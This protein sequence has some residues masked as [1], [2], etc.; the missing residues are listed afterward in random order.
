MNKSHAIAAAA[1]TLAV[2]LG[3]AVYLGYRAENTLTQ[4]AAQGSGGA[5][6]V[7]A[8]QPIRINQVKHDR[9]L[10]RSSGRL[11]FTYV[12]NCA[13]H[14]SGVENFTAQV[15]YALDHLPLPTGLARFEWS[16]T[17]QGT[18]AETFKTLFGSA[19]ALNGQG[20]IG[21]SGAIQSTLGL[22][23]VALRKPGEA[24]DMSPSSGSLSI[25]GQALALQWTLERA[26]V[27]SNGQ[28]LDIQGVG[29]DLD[30]D[31]RSRGT[32]SG[33]FKIAQASISQGSLQGL[34]IKTSAH[35]SND[36]ID[37]TIST[38]LN[39]LDVGELALSDLR[40]EWALRGLHTTSMESLIRLFEDSCGMEALTERESQAAAQAVKTLLTK[41]FSLSMPVLTG[42]T[43]QGSVSGSFAV[44]LVQ[45]NTD[46]PS[47]AAQFRS[48][49][50]IALTGQVISQEQREMALATGF[51]M[52]QG[53]TLSASYEYAKGLFK[54]NT[55]TMDASFFEDLLVGA[56]QGVNSLLAQLQAKSK[57]TAAPP[58]P[59]ITVEAPTAS[60]E[61]APAPPPAPPPAPTATP[62]APVQAPATS[63]AQPPGTTATGPACVTLTTCVQQTLIAAQQDDLERVRRIATQ[64]DVLPKPDLG[65]KAVARKLNAA[66]LDALK[67]GDAANAVSQLRR[68]RQENP[69][70]VEIAAN[71]GFALL[72]AGDPSA[73]R[74]VLGEALLL[75]PRR[76]ATWGP[77]A[78]ALALIGQM[79]DAKAAAWVAFQWSGNREKLRAVYLDRAANETEP[80]LAQLYG[81][82]AN[83]ADAA[84]AGE[85]TK[86]KQ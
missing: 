78:D 75:N 62:D 74:A 61:P 67:Q 33:A 48:K 64:I 12:P 31:N 41:G 40:M 52:V 18:S 60:A 55:R 36:R 79:N 56:D 72:K 25:K 26:T 10:F 69:Q 84:L 11:T 43:Q 16:L 14:M 39:R 46:S 5:V 6:T 29:I 51:A 54:V 20:V 86:A 17:P 3:S 28:A 47:L 70:D 27:R 38:S 24:L 19:S 21:L 66:A 53:D 1:G 4:L 50:Q 83:V 13:Q 76:A 42:K 73:A 30:I 15:D 85:A 59:P 44:E 32:G 8:S 34:E 80:A 81:H 57:E 23:A 22:P 35:E 9:G 63:L 2:W 49:G 7:G 58:S 45:S 65:N 71:L 68:A 37:S 77:L 82:M